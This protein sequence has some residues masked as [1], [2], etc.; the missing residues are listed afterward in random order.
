MFQLDLV[1][2]LKINNVTGKPVILCVDDELIILSSLSQQLMRKYGQEFSI[3]AVDTAE[4]ALDIVRKCNEDNTD[5]PVVICDRLMPLMNGDDLLIQIHKSN[6]DTRKILLTGQASTSSISNAINNAN[7][8]RYISKPWSNEELLSSV[9]EALGAFYNDRFLEEKAL[10]LEKNLLFEEIKYKNLV[11]HMSGAIYIMTADSNRQFLFH[12]PQISKITHYSKDEFTYELWLS[13][14]YPEDLNRVLSKFESISFYSKSFLIEYRFF[15]K[16]NELIWLEED[17]TSIYKDRQPFLFQGIRNDITNR[18][19]AEDKLKLYA[20]EIE[21][22]NQ[23]LLKAFDQ[24]EQANKSKSEFLANITHEF[25]T[26]LNSIL[27]Y[28]QLLEMEQIGK[29]NEKQSKFVSYIY[30]SG[31]HLLALVNTILDFS[32]IDAGRVLIDKTNFDLNA[33]VK[34]VINSQ[35]ALASQKNI[36][37]ELDVDSSRDYFIFADRTRIKQVLINLSSNAI[38]FTQ[39]GRSIGFKLFQDADNTILKCW[40]AG[41]G[42]PKSEVIRVFEPFEQIRNEFTAKTKGTGLGLSIV[43]SILDLH[44]FSIQ[45]ESEELKGSTFTI[46]IGQTPILL[47]KT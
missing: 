16:D 26:P 4:L 44:G 6:P 1:N 2:K 30:E 25:N 28:C 27:G 37:I 33:L 23:K 7:L 34:E 8:Y 38:K 12:S 19:R 22:V 15:R 13:R 46:T 10:E 29:L 41:I 3:Q 39:N 17:I 5:L 31:N 32:K 42:I 45:L 40:D 43:K 14:I 9:D 21:K 36:T 35:E 47:S 24:A 11:E 20:E 18:K